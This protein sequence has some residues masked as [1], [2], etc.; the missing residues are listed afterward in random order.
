MGFRFMLDCPYIDF[1]VLPVSSEPLN[2]YCGS[3][4]VNVRHES[5]VVPSNIEDDPIR[6]DDACVGE[7]GFDVGRI[8][9]I[10]SFDL[11]IPGIERDF[12][13]AVVLMSFK[14]LGDLR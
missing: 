7:A 6:T 8:L 10:S 2:E 4:V 11:L 5:I 13:S 14:F 12:D 1:V 9:P 3:P